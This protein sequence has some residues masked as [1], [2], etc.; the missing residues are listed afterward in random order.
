MYSLRPPDVRLDIHGRYPK[1]R[2]C[3]CERQ[4]KRMLATTGNK[5]G[6][7]YDMERKKNMPGPGD[8]LKKKGGL[9]YP[10]YCK[11][12]RVSAW[13]GPRYVVLPNPGE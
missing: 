10:N 2:K 5:E 13:S 6:G 1:I 4:G 7:G 9:S 11:K 12:T 8:E 3:V